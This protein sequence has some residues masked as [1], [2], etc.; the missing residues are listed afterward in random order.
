MVPTIRTLDIQSYDTAFSKKETADYSAITTWGV[1]YP[2]EV[3]PAIILLDA[4]KGR[5]DFP[6]LK[7]VAMDQYQ[8]WDPE[9]VIVE[10]KGFWSIFITRD[11]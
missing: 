1:F 4:I 9:T 7:N 3:T 11:A 10:A 8:Y 2:D 5:W 6:E